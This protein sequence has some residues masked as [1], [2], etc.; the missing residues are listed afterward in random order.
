MS[1]YKLDARCVYPVVK[2]TADIV[3]D[4]P[5]SDFLQEHCFVLRRHIAYTGTISVNVTYALR[6]VQ[7]L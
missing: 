1:A 5:T 6:E 4:V 2:F 3:Q 7:L